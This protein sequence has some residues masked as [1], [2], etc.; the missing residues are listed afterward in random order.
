MA[1]L[2]LFKAETYFLYRKNNYFFQ[3]NIALTIFWEKNNFFKDTSDYLTLTWRDIY[4]DLALKFL[5][6][7]VQ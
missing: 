7:L 4:D 1:Y 6:A 5:V 3:V 2:K